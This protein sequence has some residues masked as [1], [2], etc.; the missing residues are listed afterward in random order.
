MAPS[1]RSAAGTESAKAPGRR[2][3]DRIAR[4]TVGAKRRGHRVG[5]GT[6]AIASV[7]GTSA[8]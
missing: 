1:A 4:G 6:D 5:Y 7:H 8:N 3:G 2:L